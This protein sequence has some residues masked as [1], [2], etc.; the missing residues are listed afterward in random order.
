[1]WFLCKKGLYL[2]SCI[3]RQTSAKFLPRQT[4]ALLWRLS[5]RKGSLAKDCLQ[6][7]VNRI[8][9]KS[10]EKYWARYILSYN[11]K[12]DQKLKVVYTFSLISC[13]SRQWWP[14]NSND[15]YILNAAVFSS[16]CETSALQEVYVTSSFT[17]HSFRVISGETWYCLPIHSYAFWFLFNLE[18]ICVSFKCKYNS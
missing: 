14:I 1:M 10:L 17:G 7:L 2:E 11:S 9:I 18:C 5:F 6:P 15:F 4:A 3:F 12:R 8:S 13:M 16:K